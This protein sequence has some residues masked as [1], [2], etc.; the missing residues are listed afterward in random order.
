MPIIPA[1]GRQGMKIDKVQD[2]D[3]IVSS[4]PAEVYNKILSPKY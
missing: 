3:Y 2:L 4:K 1:L